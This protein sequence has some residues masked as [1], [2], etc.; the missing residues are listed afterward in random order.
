RSRQL[1]QPVGVVGGSEAVDAD[2]RKGGTHRID[3][4]RCGAVE[5]E[6]AGCGLWHVHRPSRRQGEREPESTTLTGLAFDSNPAAHE[7][8]QVLGN[9]KPQAGSA[10]TAGGSFVCLSK[11]LE[12]TLLSGLGNADARILDLEK[13]DHAVPLFR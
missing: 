7:L 6:A 11:A 10:K 13:D 8:D 12:D 3:A 9:G 2:R 1:L 5:N 4:L